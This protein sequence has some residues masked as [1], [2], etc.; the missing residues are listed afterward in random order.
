MTGGGVSSRPE[1]TKSVTSEKERESGPTG[2]GKA[3]IPFRGTGTGVRDF[4]TSSSRETILDSDRVVTDV[5]SDVVFDI[6]KLS[7]DETNVSLSF[8]ATSGEVS[9]SF[10]FGDALEIGSR[11]CGAVE[12]NCGVPVSN[13]RRE[14]GGLSG[15]NKSEL[16]EDEEK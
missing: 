1:V 2:L 12:I 6:D 7:T 11:F 14:T 5:T 15:D 4:G 13:S 9:E 3:P 8:T 16:N 10:K